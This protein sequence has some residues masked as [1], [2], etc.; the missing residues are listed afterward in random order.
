[1]LGS[2]VFSHGEGSGMNVIDCLSE[3]GFAQ[4]IVLDGVDC[5]ESA[6][7][8]VLLALMPYTAAKR[9]SEGAWIHPYYDVSQQAY[10]AAVAIARETEGATLRDDIRVKPIF[11]RLPAFTQGRNT[12]SYTKEY[13]SRFHV[14]I[15]TVT[16]PIPATDHLTEE[17]HGLHCGDCHACEAACP[18]N[19]LEGGVF[20]RERCLRNWMFSGQIVPE[21]VREQMGNRLIGCDVCQL[22]CPHNAVPVTADASALSLQ[23]LLSSPKAAAQSLRSRIGANLAIPNRVLSQSCIL[24]GCSGDKTL[25]PLVEALRNHPSPVVAEHAAWAAEKLNNPDT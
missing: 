3:A 25:L 4:V 20:H 7:C 11:A 8:S 16:P 17:P 2:S 14:Q 19:A 10:M 5:G 23:E 9:P 6:S 15:L 21:A 13:G 1:M 24:A 12:L 18:T 22:V